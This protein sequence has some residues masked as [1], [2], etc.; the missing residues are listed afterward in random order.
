MAIKTKW[1]YMKGSWHYFKRQPGLRQAPLRTIFRLL[2]WRVRC[3][4]GLPATIKLP[5]W[6]ARFFLPPAW[7]GA[8]TTSIFAFR[9]KYELELTYLDLFVS[10]GMVV[11]D[12]GASYGIYT[13]AASK[14]VGDLGQ[15]LS[16]EPGVWCFS[17]LKHNI[18]INHL[19]NVLAF[20]L[21]LSDRA[22]KARLYHNNGGPIG[23]SLGKGKG[24][25]GDFEEIFTTTIDKVL[26][27]EGV[28]KVDFLKLDVEGAEELVLHGAKRLLSRIRPIVV[29]E[30]FPTA[31]GRFGLSKDGTWGFLKALG[32]HF[33]TLGNG[34]M[35][36]RLVPTPPFGNW[37]RCNIVAIHQ[38]RGSLKIRRS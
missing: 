22:G 33:F 9:E 4:F 3:L 38:Q 2:Y 8:G 14:L 11:V 23:Y 21:A 7:G 31:L 16:F 19:S 24:G 17:I 27:Q 5:R 15:I 1:H 13:V 20:R 18:A 28:S 25:G 35:L 29:F 37:E 26:V 34:G 10:P 32:Y 36:R 30:I 6:D 12:A